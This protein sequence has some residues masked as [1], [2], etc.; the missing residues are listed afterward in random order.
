MEDMVLSRSARALLADRSLHRRV[1]SFIVRAKRHEE[2]DP[3][4]AA[5][6]ILKATRAI[7]G[8]SR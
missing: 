1:W 8:V 3:L 2:H 7:P 5:W 6:A 4:A